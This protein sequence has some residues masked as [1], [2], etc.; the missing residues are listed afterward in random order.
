M[1]MN[2][3]DAYYEPE[4]DFD[5]DSLEEQIYDAVANDPDYDPAD[6]MNMSE[7]IGQESDNEEVQ[8]FIKDCVAAKDW[9]KLGM[10]LYQLSW[11]YQES[12]VEYRLTK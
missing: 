9:A 2:R 4:D 1:G 10:K 6:M 12:I 11:D 5:G 8:Q 3:H 7:A